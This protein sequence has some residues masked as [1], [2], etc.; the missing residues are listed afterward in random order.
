MDAVA[1]RLKAQAPD[2]AVECAFLELQAP[3]LPAALAKLSGSGVSQVT[4][5]PMFLG[6]GKHAREDL[7]QLVSAARARHPGVR[8]DVLPPVGE[9]AAVLDLLALL[10][11]QGSQT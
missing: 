10:A 7:P 1:A 5:L 2:V 11:V 9:H 4:V 6:V 8:I 3:D